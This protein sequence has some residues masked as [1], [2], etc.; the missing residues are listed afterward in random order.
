MKGSHS[1]KDF[2]HQTPETNF[3]TE[4]PTP[5]V[6]TFTTAR[7]SFVKAVVQGQAAFQRVVI[8][9]TSQLSG[10]KADPHEQ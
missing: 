7:V 5:E 9:I 3:N 1:L 2:K 4:V 10:L 8:F 6:P